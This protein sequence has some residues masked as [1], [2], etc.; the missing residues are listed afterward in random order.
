MLENREELMNCEKLISSSKC[1]IT[2]LTVQYKLY[3][4]ELKLDFIHQD[5][6]IYLCVFYFFTLHFLDYTNMFTIR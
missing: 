3:Q 5:L 2:L 6:I 1:K 4:L